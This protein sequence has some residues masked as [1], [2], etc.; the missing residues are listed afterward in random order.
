M[1]RRGTMNEVATPTAPS[2][3]PPALVGR[4]R[5]RAILHDALA[6]ALAGRGGLVLIGGEA[7]IGKTTLAEAALA[8]A[9]RRG[10]QTLVG[11]S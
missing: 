5:E 9:A 10:L 4:H 6:A 11:K 1:W 2:S 3:R 8:E 7:G